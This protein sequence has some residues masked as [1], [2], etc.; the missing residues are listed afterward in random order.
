METFDVKILD[1]RMI[2]HNVRSYTIEKPAGYIYSPGQATDVSVLKEGWDKEKRP[3]TFTSL[4]DAAV[5]EF[6]IKSYTDHDGVTNR[7]FTLVPG[8]MLQI[9][10]AWGTIQYKGEGV[11]IAG[12]A[13]VTPFIAIFRNLFSKFSIGNNQLFFSNRTSSD[14]ILKEEFDSMLGNNFHNI[15]TGEQTANFYNGR[16]NKEYLQRKIS[17][18]A[19]PFYVCGPD[20]FTEQI[21]QALNESGANAEALV[22][23]K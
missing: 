3:F 20:R 2:T 9:G 17:N 16:I 23:E 12:G 7:L 8:D 13:G 18:F 19:Q 5:L 21:L 6:T 22:F 1:I 14:I 15:I 11:F 10:D 4:N